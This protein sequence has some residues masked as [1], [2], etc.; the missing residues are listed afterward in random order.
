[1]FSFRKVNIAHGARFVRRSL[2]TRVK[3]LF[4]PENIPKIGFVIGSCALVVQVM[5]LY[6][7]HEILSSQFR[8]VEVICLFLVY[9]SD[10]LSENSIAS[11]W[12]LQCFGLET[13]SNSAS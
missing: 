7:K 13:E 10:F 3:K 2:T 11:G 9:W 4:V 8:D 1:M 6:P 12:N 5:L